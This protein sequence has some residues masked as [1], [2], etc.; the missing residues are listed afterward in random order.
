MTLQEFYAS[1][2]ENCD[3]V[4]KRF[5]GSSAMLE[6]FLKKFLDDKT[7]SQLCDAM[8]A[9]GQRRDF[10]RRAYDEGTCGQLRF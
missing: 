6:K 3:E 5:G 2:N 10:P 1:I 4:L 8:E 7:Y 9:G